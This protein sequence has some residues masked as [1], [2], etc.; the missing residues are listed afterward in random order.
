MLYGIN[1]LPDSESSTQI[2]GQI[3]I[4]ENAKPIDCA[5]PATH[6]K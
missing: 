2:G 3:S 4:V 1:V 5:F 6:L